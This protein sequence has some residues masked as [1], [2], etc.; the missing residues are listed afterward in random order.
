MDF[1]IILISSDSSEES[2]GTSTARVILF[3]T[4]P[5]TIPSTAPTVD[6]PVIH[7]DTPLIPTYTPTIS[8][9]VPII[10]PISP[11]IQ[12][13]SPFICTDSSDSDTSEKPP[14]HDPYEATVACTQPNGVLKMLTARKSVRSLP[15]HRLTLRYSADY[16]SSDHFTSDDSSRDSSSPLSVSPCDSPTAT[17]AGLSR[18]RCRSPTTSVPVASPVP[19]ALSP[20]HADLFLPC[21][22]IRYSNSESDSEVSS[23]E[24]YMTYVPREIGLGV[25]LEDSYEPYT[26]PNIDPEV[27]I[28]DEEEVESSTGG[29]TE[30]EVDRVTYPVVLDDTAEPVRED[31]PELVSVDGSFK[32]DQGHMIMATSQ[33]GV[34]MSERIGTLVQD[35]FHRRPPAKGVGLR[36]A[37]SYTGNHPKD[38]FTQLETIRRSYNV[39]R[40]KISFELEG[41]TFEPKRGYVIKPPVEWG[42]D[43][44]KVLYNYITHLGNW[45]GSFFFIDNK[46]IP[47]DYPELLLGENKL[48]KKSFKD[49][50]PF[51]PEMNLCL[52]TTWKHSPKKLVI[53]HRGQEMDFKS[54]MLR[55]VDGELNFLL[56]E[57]ASKG[58]NS[59]FAKFMNNN[60]PIIYATPISSVYPSNVAENV[61]DSDD[62]SYGEDEQTLVGLSL[63]FHPKASKNSKF[64]A[65]G[66]LL[67][68]FLER[69][70]L[71]KFK[72]CLPELNSPSAKELKD[73]TDCH[74]VVAH[75]TSPSWK[76]HLR[77]ISIEAYAELE[78]KCNE[79]LQDLDK[80]PLVSGMCAEI[81]ALQGQEIDN[82]KQDSIALVPKVIPDAAMKL[83]HSDDLGV[84]LAKLVRSSVIYGRQAFEEVATIEEP[85]VLE[86]M[87]S[88][89]PSSKEEYDQAAEYVANPYASL[90]QLLLKKPS[91]LRPT[92]SGSRSKPL[93]L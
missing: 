48:D 43:V 55:V 53:Y 17:S 68:V 74:W 13:T 64:L 59:P 39:I 12:Y 87:S 58:Q 85:F 66:R 86:K 2:V 24:G 8:P 61:A 9:I 51:H 26:K 54:F 77:E 35:N 27:G 65:R 60:A 20:V 32:R 57:G 3:D 37:D 56:V 22:R 78:R 45:K 23:E 30:I 46:I 88:Y 91:L 6:L 90:E 83:I 36:V 25:E 28:A 44:P 70:C 67:L 16:S 79:A 7:D 5:T 15:T 93:P 38:D 89:R 63:S 50:V 29:T 47:S 52:R 75:V 72:K 4:I 49:K 18:K 31:S 92:Y 14:S 19:I 80:N 42:A 11:I 40:E 41:E 81:K 1:S 69:P 34:A 62:P 82:L 71:R 73:V 21:K 84:L 10:P 33:Q 76:Q